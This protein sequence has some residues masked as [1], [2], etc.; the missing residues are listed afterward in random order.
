M[1]GSL[2]QLNALSGFFCVPSAGE[3]RYLH[4][5]MYL[6]LLLLLLFAVG[7]ISRTALDEPEM[8]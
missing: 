5:L 2:L 3:D 6:D 7:L 4:V 8:N 1:K